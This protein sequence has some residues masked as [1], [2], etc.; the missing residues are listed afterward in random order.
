[1]KNLFTVACSLLILLSTSCG[2]VRGWWPGVTDPISAPTNGC[3]KDIDVIF[4]NNCYN[5]LIVFFLEVNPGSE[6]NC[7]KL[8]NIGTIDQD[9]NTKIVTIHKG[10]IGYFVFAESINGQCTG[11][12][13]KAE[14]FVEYSGNTSNQVTLSMCQ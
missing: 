3:N 6:I 5:S 11:G 4:N 9:Q 7:E 13:R 1:M 8:Y 2:K 12:K 14:R 10:K